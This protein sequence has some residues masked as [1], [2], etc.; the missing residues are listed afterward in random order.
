MVLHYYKNADGTLPTPV[1]IRNDYSVHNNKWSKL[2]TAEGSALGNITEGSTGIN[3]PYMRY[4]DVLLMYAEAANELN[5]GPTDKAIDCLMQVHNRAFLE[6]DP[7]FIAQAQSGKEAFQKAV[8]DERKWEFAGENSRWR[9]LVRTNTYGEELVYSFLRYYSAGM[10]NAQGWT[11]AMRMP[12]TSTT[13]THE[14]G[15]IDNLPSTY[16]LST[17]T[18]LTKPMLTVCA[19]TRLSSMA[20]SS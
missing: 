3:Y 2:W 9:D 18:I 10:Q 16:L 5:G 11:Q 6:G 15:Y 12:S 14:A 19:C 1:V 7:E 8:L 4:A 20:M 17:S 13:A